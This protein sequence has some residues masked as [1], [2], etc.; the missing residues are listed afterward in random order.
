MMRPSTKLTAIIAV[1]FVV[2]WASFNQK[3]EAQ[4]SGNGN[5]SAE[6]DLTDKET[7]NLR[8]AMP[9]VIAYYFH[10]TNRCASCKKIEAYSRDAI[11]S[12]FAEELSNGTIEFRS[13]N[14]DKAENKHF[15]KDYQLYTKSLV[16]CD[17]IDGKQVQWKN[18][19]KVWQ[20]IRN[21]DEFLKYVQDE[22][23]AYLRE[24]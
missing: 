5:V 13:I 23:D 3:G 8:K 2:I 15:I 4:A 18:L 9:E 20:L 10:T 21:K 12:G 22:I 16:I 7:S 24:R 19:A 11:E 14:L 1:S 6:T 17:Q